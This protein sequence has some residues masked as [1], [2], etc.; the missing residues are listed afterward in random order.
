MK[1]IM[2]LIAALSVAA[3]LLTACNNGSDSADVNAMPNSG[4]M[5]TGSTGD[6]GNTGEGESAPPADDGEAEVLPPDEGSG[7]GEEAGEPETIEILPIP[8]VEFGPGDAWFQP[9]DPATI[10]LAAGKV[11]FFEFSAVW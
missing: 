9:T 1:R 5:N 7:G 11:Q 2:F 6:T 10:Q 8:D 4:E 3:I